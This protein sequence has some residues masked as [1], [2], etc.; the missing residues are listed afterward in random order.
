VH[1]ANRL[2]SN[3]LLE[4]T[5]FAARVAQDIN[6]SIPP[7][8]NASL[9]DGVA[10]RAPTNHAANN[11]ADHH[12]DNDERALRA[13]MSAEVGV[14]RSGCGLAHAL[15]TIRRME[16]AAATPAIRNMATAALLIAAAAYLRKES[17]GAHYRSDFRNA[18]PILARRSFLTL[19]EAHAVAEQAAGSDGD[20]LL[21]LARA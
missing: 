3:S 20:L 14:V 12:N 5:V 7:Q 10:S 21:A 16:T 2:A 18:D 1:G 9:A 6:D 4:A 11:F 8:P 13:M 17:R 15:A 19:A